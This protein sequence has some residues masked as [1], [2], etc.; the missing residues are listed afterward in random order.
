MKHLSKSLA[1]LVLLSVMICSGCATITSRQ[2]L[3]PML[4]PSTK[5]D[6]AWLGEALFP[7]PQFNYFEGRSYTLAAICIVDLPISLVT[8]TVLLPYDVWMVLREEK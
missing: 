4:Y 2:M 5:F 1:C 8:D 6:A 3:D 7:S